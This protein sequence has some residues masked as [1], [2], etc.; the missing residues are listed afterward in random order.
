M[1]RINVGI[2][3]K[4]LCDEH[5]LAEHREIKRL[6][7]SK[8]LGKPSK[9]FVLGKGHVTFFKDKGKFTLKRYISIYNECKLRGFNVTDYRS[10]W[11]NY[12]GNEYMPTPDAI[13]LIS[14]RIIERLSH[15]KRIHYY[16]RAID[17]P[18]AIIM[19]NEAINKFN[20]GDI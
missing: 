20:V 14:N 2:P 16:G 11:N 4:M 3:V 8:L 5:L 1:T 10:S 12:D 19:I 9:F 13:N 7:N 15:M 18:T 6:P 17:A